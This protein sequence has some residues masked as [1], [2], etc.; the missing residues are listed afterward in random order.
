MRLFFFFVSVPIITL[1]KKTPL[2]SPL[3]HQV[4]IKWNRPHGFQRNPSAT[5]ISAISSITW[6]SP[7]RKRKNIAST[8]AGCTPWCRRAK[9]VTSLRWTTPMWRICVE[10]KSGEW[11]ISFLCPYCLLY[12]KYFYSGNFNFLCS[13]W[14]HLNLTS[15]KLSGTHKFITCW[16]L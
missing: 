8:L 16:I 6:S 12:R 5:M 13:C 9:R 14:K 1:P 15:R 7:A 2:Q 10:L 3:H 11:K 4:L